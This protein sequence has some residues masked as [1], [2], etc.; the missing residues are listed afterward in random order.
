M[1]AAD[2][3]VSNLPEADLS[4]A[5]D[6][7]FLHFEARSG[8]AGKTQ[9]AVGRLLKTLCPP[10]NKNV[11]QNIFE[12][13]GFIAPFPAMLKFVGQTGLREIGFL[14]RRDKTSQIIWDMFKDHLRDRKR[15][16]CI[17][18]RPSIYHPV[19]PNVG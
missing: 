8:R 19:R 15:S 10:A 2:A 17:L 5:V 16:S 11:Q 1:F 9:L 6:L 3:K 4:A 7:V 13:L 12:H 18:M 14:L